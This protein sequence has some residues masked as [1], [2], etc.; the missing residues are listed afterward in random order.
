[1]KNFSLVII[2]IAL[3][4]CNPNERASISAQ[5]LVDNA[6]AVSG[7]DLYSQSHI[8]FKFR[9]RIYSSEPVKGQKI[10][11]RL[12]RN[13]TIQILDVKEP[14]NFHR[15][16]NDSLVSLSDSLANVYSNSVNSVH[17]FA[18]LPYGLN[19]RAVNKELLG[20]I[21]IRN[22]DYYKVKVTFSQEEG[23]DDFED[24]YIYW[25]NKE[26]FKPDYLAYE[27]HVDKGG[28]RFREAINER[29]I[30]GIR[31]VDYN[32]F[33]PI[34]ANNILEIDSLFLKNE[35]KLLSKIELENI[36]VSRNH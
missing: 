27:F 28:F 13:D 5:T 31:F 11:K 24:V 29:Y 19:D 1:M 21:K 12:L 18:Y 26:T 34:M 8:Q 25:F 6:I 32:N 22:K 36:T 30:N 3:F 10:L 7:G 14:K 16:I 20:E 17:Y 35:L 23:G 33:S 15:F 4:S 9:D 2:V